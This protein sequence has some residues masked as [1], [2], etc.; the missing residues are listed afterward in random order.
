MAE[1]GRVAGAAVAEARGRGDGARGDDSARAS[2][3][4]V[5]GVPVGREA[6]GGAAGA[7]PAVALGAGSGGAGG[8]AD[9]LG[10]GGPAAGC[11]VRP[12]VVLPAA[13]APE[14]FGVTPG[15][16]GHHTGMY[17]APVAA[18]R[19]EAPAGGG[20]VHGGLAQAAAP[21]AAAATPP[22]PRGVCGTAQ[23]RARGRAHTHTRASLGR[24]TRASTGV[25]TRPPNAEQAYMTASLPA[26]RAR[27]GDADGEGYDGLR[28]ALA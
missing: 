13:G 25:S 11:A 6:P 1:A 2:G 16:G 14:A 5:E 12:V 4:V 23:R 3:G 7:G 17:P 9:A 21:S 15:G 27:V 28:R 18:A 24:F 19:S 26:G 20:S 10:A 8:G 22:P